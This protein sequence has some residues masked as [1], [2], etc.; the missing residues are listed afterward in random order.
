MSSKTLKESTKDQQNSFKTYHLATNRQSTI[1][2]KYIGKLEVKPQ[3]QPK[4]SLGVFGA[5]SPAK[6]FSVEFSPEPESSESLVT[7]VAYVGTSKRYELILHITNYGSKTV[8]A[9]IW[10][11]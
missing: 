8:D 5:D 6:G 10:Q 1:F 9:K 3:Q 4:I 7:Q 2:T 11:I